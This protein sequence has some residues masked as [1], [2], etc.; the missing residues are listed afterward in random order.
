MFTDDSNYRVKFESY[1]ERHFIKNFQKKYKNQWDVTRKA[2]IAQ[3]SHI[4]QLVESGRTASPI[5]RSDDNKE[6]II[7]HEFA[8]AQQRQSP[9]SSGNRAIL[10]VNH[11]NRIVHVLLVYYKDD[12]G[13]SANETALWHAHIKKEYKELLESFGL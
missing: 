2:L 10:Y 3:F 9:K 11:N 5:H 8:V 6:W 4:N 7:K 1:S 13:K 12:L